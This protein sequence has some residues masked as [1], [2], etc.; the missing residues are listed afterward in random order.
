MVEREAILSLIDQKGCLTVRVTPNARSE[1]LA[2]DAE[3]DDGAK[4]KIWVTVPPE[5]GKANKAVIKL[6]AKALGLPKSTL[7][8]ERG[9]TSRT[10]LIRV[11]R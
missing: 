2:I 10:K 11:S 6:L 5:D 7:D 3:G 8:L 1:R 9:E 4:L